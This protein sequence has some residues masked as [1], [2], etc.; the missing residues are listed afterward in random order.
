MLS[1]WSFYTAPYPIC[2]YSILA[3]RNPKRAYWF[4]SLDQIV[5]LAIPR[6]ER[7][8]LLQSPLMNL[9][10]HGTVPV[11]RH[12]WLSPKDRKTDI[13]SIQQESKIFLWSW[14]D[15]HFI[16]SEDLKTR[17]N[18]ASKFLKILSRKLWV[19]SL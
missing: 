14:W 7:F 19:K 5:C 18:A 11:W 3:Y 8:H 16:T 6:H 1:N 13:L 2:S 4:R 12:T 15:L 17:Y 10:K 9:K